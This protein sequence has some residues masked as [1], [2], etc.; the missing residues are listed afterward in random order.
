[1]GKLNDKAVQAADVGKHADGE[2]L[3]LLVK[4][5]GTKVWWFR[6]R[7]GGKE[8]TLSIGKYP[9]IN[10]KEARELT[11]DARKLL[12]NG[13]DPMVVKREA[14]VTIKAAAAPVETFSL[15]M[16]E[17]LEAKTKRSSENH[18]RD[19]RRSMDLHVLPTFGK[20]DIKEISAIE[21]IQLGKK[22][23]DAGRYLA[24]RIIQ[25]VGEVMN[26]AVATGRREQNPVTKMTH[27]TLAPHSR[28]N[29][30]AISMNELPE[31]LRDF[32]KYRGFPITMLMMRFVLLTASRTGE[33]RDL[34]W[35]WVDL[36]KRL[37]TIPA[38][39]YKTGRK[40]Q[41]QGKKAPPHFIPLSNQVTELL[42]EAQEL[43]GNSGEKRVF[44]A[45]RNYAGKASENALSNALAHI[46]SGKWKGKQSGHGFRRLARTAWGDHG[47]W[48]F[49]A[50]ERQLAHTVGNSTVA[51][52][53]KAE[54]IEERARMLQWWADQVSEAGSAK[55]LEFRKTA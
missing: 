45:Y 29:N 49:E 41:N 17:L 27:A 13:S 1:M 46:A 37:I 30:P 5:N 40:Q 53:D 4:P 19:Y 33:A 26:F 52:Y 9:L 47:G 3:T 12:A 25:R 8:K 44:P 22:T 38:G 20:R 10:L 48:S 55:V 31:F 42:I 35:D 36:D 39:G 51:A 11:Y 15:I 18:V 43:T 14:E 28:E 50:M 32:A 7:Y 23:E 6:Y 24:H 54:R 34:I 21:I 16:E 2:G